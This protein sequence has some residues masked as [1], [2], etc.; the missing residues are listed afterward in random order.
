MKGAVTDAPSAPPAATPAWREDGLRLAVPLLVLLILQLSLF[1]WSA[2]RGLDFTDESYYLLSYLHWREFVATATFFGAFFEW[3]FRW[4][5]QDVAAIRVFGMALLVGGGGFFTWRAMAFDGDR[6]QYGPRPLP[7]VVG[8]MVAALFYYSYLTT[9]RAPSYNLLVLFCMLV[10]TGL[11]LTLIEGRSSRARLW[12]AALGYGLAMGACALTKATSA[13]AT[14]LCHLLFFAFFNREPR[15]SALALGAAA[16]LGID[17]AV[18]QFLQPQWLQVLRDGVTLA[19]TLDGRY[20]NFPITTLWDAVLRGGARLLPSLAIAALVFG[21]VVRRWGRKHRWVLSS[22]VMLLVAG[23]MLTIQLQGYGKSWWALLV[24][25]TALLWLAERLCRERTLPARAALPTVG[26]TALLF[27]LPV[28]YSVG[29]NGSLPAH[30]QMAAVF[31]VVAMMLPLRRLWVLGLIHRGALVVTLAALCLP[32]LITQL[33]SLQDPAFTYRLRAGMLVQS[34]P[35]SLGSQ[36]KT[37][38]LDAAIHDNVEAL[39]SALR[40]AGYTA[41]EPMLDVTGDGPGLVYALGGRPVGVAWLIGGYP[42][43]ERMAAQVLDKVPAATLRKTWVLSADDNMRALRSW[44]NLL[45]ERAGEASH[46][47]VASLPYRAQYRWDGLPPEPT[48]LSLWKP[49]APG[50]PAAER[51]P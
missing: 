39:G 20:T 22:L 40:Q 5:G 29:T 18:L 19:T 35:T 3:P 37:L 23:I 13:A 14:L 17:L 36:G 6:G 51:A 11:L 4:L 38:E 31:A 27:A 10:A 45:R 50:A 49:T 8:G 46:E 41:G 44:R 34:V 15:T 28:A 48:T 21:L 47:R 25:G 16:G 42:G 33:R 7:F 43:S 2:P 12:G 9:L 30:T 1:V 24:F 32:T 26:L